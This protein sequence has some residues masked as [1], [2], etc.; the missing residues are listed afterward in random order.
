MSV[1]ALSSRLRDRVALQ[2]WEVIG[3]VGFTRVGL[4]EIGQRTRVF[5][6]P[7][8]FFFVSVENE[9][10]F[11][12][13]TCLI[14]A[15]Y[16]RSRLVTR[17]LRPVDDV[18]LGP[19]LSLLYVR[20]C[21]E[22]L[23]VVDSA[24]HKDPPSLCL[25][26]PVWTHVTGPSESYLWLITVPRYTSPFYFNVNFFTVVIFLECNLGFKSLPLF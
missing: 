12:Q 15:D 13:R 22:L 6:R 7:S 21:V 20:E 4:A 23:T 11:L 9:R 19:F 2:S 1:F 8:G 14:N 25:W 26:D 24:I 3:H 18:S 17:G 10:K 16:A 5:Q